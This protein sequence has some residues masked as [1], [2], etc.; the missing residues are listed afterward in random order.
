MWPGKPIQD[1]IG[2]STLGQVSS[3]SL[4]LLQILWLQR[5]KLY[6]DLGSGSD[7]S[8]PSKSLGSASAWP[9][10]RLEAEE[11]SVSPEVSEL[12]CGNNLVLPHVAN[13]LGEISLKHRTLL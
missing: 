6:C 4:R 1:G 13:V 3:A 2:G 8:E 11:V 5:G 9:L 12:S 7:C 10:W